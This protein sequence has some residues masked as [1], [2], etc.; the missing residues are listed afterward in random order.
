MYKINDYSLFPNSPGIYSITCGETGKFYIGSSVNVRE[1][2]GQHVYRLKKNTHSNPILQAIWN[3]DQ[4]RLVFACVEIVQSKEKAVILQ[5]EQRHLD[6]AGVGRNRMCMNV[7]VTAN[8]H[9]GLKRSE[10]TKR[11]LR[12]ASLGKK[13]SPD[14]IEKLRL[15]KIGK[16][17][18]PE[19]I[20]KRTAG[21]KGKKINRPKG[22]WQ[23]KTR[24]FT[25]EQVTEMRLLKAQGVSYSKLSAIFGVSHGGLQKIIA[26]TTYGDVA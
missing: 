15:A 12:E 10:E 11:K 20:K 17:Q 3:D 13:L 25:A 16:K 23:P 21:Q 26:R 7:L 4:L 1:R 9:L 2:I 22:I 24:K 19:H 8:S 6:K 5:A 14:H 18:S